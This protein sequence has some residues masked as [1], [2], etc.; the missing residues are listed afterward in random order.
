MRLMK[1]LL[2]DEEKVPV[3]QRQ[4]IENHLKRNKLFVE[5]EFPKEKENRYVEADDIQIYLTPQKEESAKSN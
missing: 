1:Q 2:F 5:L 3:Q 4:E